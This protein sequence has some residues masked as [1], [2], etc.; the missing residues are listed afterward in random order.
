MKEDHILEELSKIILDDKIGVCF[1]E[2]EYKNN[3]KE[4][5]RRYDAKIPPGYKDSVKQK[6]TNDGKR[7]Y[8]DFLIWEELIAK[9]KSSEKPILF[10]TDDAKDDWWLIEGT[11]TIMPCEELLIEFKA[12]T[13]NHILISK[14]PAFLYKFNPNKESSV[15]EINSIQN[16]FKKIDFIELYKEAKNSPYFMRLRGL[17]YMPIASQEAASQ[18]CVNDMLILLPEPENIYDKNAIKVLTKDNIHIGYIPTSCCDH[19]LSMIKKN[20][21]LNAKVGIINNTETIPFIDIKLK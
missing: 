14:S 20:E 6:E 8:G 17:K 11:Q 12:R 10:I 21:H 18:L 7:I 19:V 5:K 15:E 4:G 2:E 1:T 9:S 3:F 16:R 13:G